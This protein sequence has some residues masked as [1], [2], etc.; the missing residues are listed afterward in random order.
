MGDKD[1]ASVIRVRALTKLK[2]ALKGANLT[3]TVES[4][5]TSRI[6]LRVSSLGIDVD[7][8]TNPK[9]DH[10]W[11]YWLDGKPISP[12]D[13]TSAAAEAIKHRDTAEVTP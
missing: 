5:G 12:A 6:V 9:D 11:W 3:S 13:E 7:C 4:S 1:P 2:T 10:T 8:R